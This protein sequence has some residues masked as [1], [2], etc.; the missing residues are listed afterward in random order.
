MKSMVNKELHCITIKEAKKI[1][2]EYK[3]ETGWQ[4]KMT[5]EKSEYQRRIRESRQIPTLI[6]RLQ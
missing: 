5:Y 4:T 2:D 3:E 6:Q 1:I